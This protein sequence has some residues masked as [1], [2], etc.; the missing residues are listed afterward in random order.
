[1][2]QGH[3][4]PDL[5]SAGEETVAVRKGASCFDPAS[6][7]GMIRGR[8]IHAAD[9]RRATQVSRASDVAIG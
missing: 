4:R 6:G 5:I 2:K 7:L 1:M 9:P 8:K 3:G